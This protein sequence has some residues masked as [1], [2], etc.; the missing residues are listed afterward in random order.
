MIAF[1]N[2]KFLW[3]F[4]KKK[5]MHAGDVGICCVE[6]LFGING[7]PFGLTCSDKVGICAC[8][9]TLLKLLSF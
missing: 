1:I 8:G 4:F 6:S 7:N 3:P 2:C 5:I 9:V